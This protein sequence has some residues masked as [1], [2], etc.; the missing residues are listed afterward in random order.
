VKCKACKKE[1]T[2]KCP[3]KVI[4][5]VPTILS[6]GK[7][8]SVGDYEFVMN[9]KP[10]I[11]ICEE[12]YCKELHLLGLHIMESFDLMTKGKNDHS[13]VVQPVYIGFEWK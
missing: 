1:I 13:K 9:I 10:K 2:T 8:K 6:K 11:V 7:G 4:T 5:R 12:C 3:Q